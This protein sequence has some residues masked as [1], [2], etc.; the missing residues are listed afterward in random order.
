MSVGRLSVTGIPTVTIEAGKSFSSTQTGVLL[1]HFL[2][3]IQPLSLRIVQ[4]NAAARGRR[5]EMRGEFDRSQ[6]ARLPHF[7]PASEE[8]RAVRLAKY[9]A[10]AFERATVSTFRH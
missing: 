8:M 6:T 3:K 1:E 7:E 5:R 9:S 10:T 4:L 2:E